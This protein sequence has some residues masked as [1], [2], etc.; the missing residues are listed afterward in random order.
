MSSVDQR[1]VKR[2][3]GRVNEPCP[4]FGTFFGTYAPELG[5]LFSFVPLLSFS[6]ER[7]K[8]RKARYS[9]VFCIGA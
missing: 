6:A 4:T 3:G 8:S 2:R 9:R 5:L 1:G 7:G